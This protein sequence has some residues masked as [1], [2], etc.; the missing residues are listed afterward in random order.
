MKRFEAGG[1]TSGRNGA[2]TTKPST[3]RPKAAIAKKGAVAEMRAED[4]EDEESEDA[5][6]EP[7][8]KKAKQVEPQN[9]RG[10]RS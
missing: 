4:G 1:A 10:D 7:P 9:G 8:R 5:E 3:K 6:A 2:A